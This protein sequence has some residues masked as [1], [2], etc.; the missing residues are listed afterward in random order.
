M[1]KA[2]YIFSYKTLL[3]SVLLCLLI[4]LCTYQDFPAAEYI[5][6]IARSPIFFMN[7]ILLFFD[8]KLSVNTQK[9]KAYKKIGVILKLFIIILIVST[10]INTAYW[11]IVLKQ[12]L[13][14]LGENVLIKAIKQLIYYIQFFLIFSCVYKLIVY[15]N[16]FKLL[17]NILF[18]VLLA[19]LFILLFEAALIPDAFPFLHFE[20]TPYY[21]V[22]LLT[23]ESSTTGS[24]VI[25]LCTC[26][27]AT[28]KNKLHISIT[29]I[30]FILYSS[31]TLSKM[32]LIALPV[33]F[34]L[35]SLIDNG[36]V[37]KKYIFLLLVLVSILIYY[38]LPMIISLM[39]QDLE[40][41]TSIVSR[42]SSFFNGFVLGIKNIFGTAGYYPY[43]FIKELPVTTKFVINLV[44]SENTSELDSWGITDDKFISAGSTLGDW[45]MLIGLIGFVLY[46]ILLKR[47]YIYANSWFLKFGVVYF[48]IVA[49]FTEVMVF[50]V[51]W[52]VFFA[53]LAA[54]H[55]KTSSDNKDLNSYEN[56]GSITRLSIST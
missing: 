3:Y 1:I 35:K 39:M 29:I 30:F 26:L 42:T 24:I 38:T 21:R 31:L 2:D 5:G 32:F 25:F 34:I 16:I 11:F 41:Y 37:Q 13:T 15:K 56:T 23:S 14:N 40:E 22:R 51:T 54:H 8:Y 48:G 44:N 19:Q 20:P 49:T 53:I 9:H 28:S 4:L 12:S 52:P 55:Y 7:P 10:L 17:P 47:L 18:L 45:M 27:L 36:G 43:Y 33:A 46:F 50:R 6:E